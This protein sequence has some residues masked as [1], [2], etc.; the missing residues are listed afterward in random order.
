[1][2]LRKAAVSA[3]CDNDLRKWRSALTRN[4]RATFTE[5]L[6]SSLSVD[7]DDDNEVTVTGIVCCGVQCCVKTGDVLTIVDRR[8]VLLPRATD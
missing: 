2:P 3:A 4:R 5:S 7:Y 8:L 1:M 6:S